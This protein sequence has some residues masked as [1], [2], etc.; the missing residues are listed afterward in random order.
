MKTA[1]WRDGLVLLALAGLILVWV[2]EAFLPGK[3]LL[4]LDIVVQMW[5][6]WQR[7]D[8]AVTVHNPLISDVVDYIYPVKAFVAE[9]IKGGTLPLWN[10]YV[11]GGYPLTYNT[12]A[13]LWYPL[14]FLYY[15]LEPVTAVDLTIALQLFL[16][17]LFLFAYLRQL[18]LRRPAAFL[19]AV[20][21]LFNGMMVVWLEW[22]VVHAAVTWLPLFLYFVERA[23]QKMEI[24]RLGDWEIS[25]K[26]PNLSISQSPLPD[27][28]LAG[29]AFVLPWLGGHWNWALYGSLTAVAYL[30]WRFGAIFLTQRG[31]GAKGQ[32]EIL[33]V[34]FLVLM[35]G[36]GLSAIQVIPAFV[37]LSQ[38]HRQPFTLAESLA[39]GLKNRAAVALLPDFFGNPIHANWWGPTNYNETAFYMGIL[40]LFLVGLA[41]V[42]RRDGMTRF[43]GVWGGLTLLWA[44]GTPLYALLW[45]LPVFNGLWPSRAVTAVVFCTAVL[46]ALALDKLLEPGVNQQRVKRGVGVVTAVLLLILLV[47]GVWYWD[48]RKVWLAGLSWFGAALLASLLLLWLRPRLGTG[49]F[50]GLVILLVTVDLFWAGHDYN[51]V[52]DVADL[53]PLTATSQFL[54][55]DPEP[56]RIATLPEGVAYPPNTNLQ[57]RLPA[58]SGYEPAI[59]QTWVEYISVAEG[60]HAIYFERE[61]MPLHGLESPLLDAVN[62]KYVVTIRDWYAETPVNGPAQELVETWVKVADTAVSQPLTM[63]DA[64]LHRIDLPLQIGEGATGAVITRIFTPDGGQELAHAAWEVGQPLTDGWASFFFSPFPAE[65]GRDFLLTVTH[66]GAGEIA[67]GASIHD[68]A[69]RSYYLPR[70]HLLH[71]DGKTRVYLNEGYFPRAY[72]VSAGLIAPNAEMA[73]ARVVANQERL[74]ETAV[75][76]IDTLVDAYTPGGTGTAVITYYTPNSITI[77]TNSDGP[78]YLVLADT[79][80]PGWQ[81]TVDGAPIDVFRANSVVRAVAIPA[82]EHEVRFTFQPVDFYVGVVITAVTLLFVVATFVASMVAKA[83]TPNRGKA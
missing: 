35:V 62:L 39:L 82:G 72:L 60:Q 52:G 42:L 16:G 26:S 38:G 18:R 48:E 27:A 1:R 45:A 21:F 71:E 9:Q 8:T 73:L 59:L 33:S 53:Y 36:V 15:V 63:P 75:L 49:L 19:G 66:D 61:L 47:Y 34:G 6:P 76:E 54:H 24:G 32:R 11:L 17:G 25:G 28:L 78:A 14:S 20:I 5:P 74:H 44:L 69:F 50:A 64:G 58:I 41:L 29:V 51:T 43:Y 13:G 46:A 83:T 81:A 56:Y 4:P 3:V 70:P 7:P 57:E 67:V 2:G 23:A 80:Y 40:P 68:L 37:Y 55:S 77:V 12:Q 22:Q 65:W 31:K 10:P 79:Y 30:I